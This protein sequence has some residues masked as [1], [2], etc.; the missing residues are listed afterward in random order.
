M[1]T[2]LKVH[3]PFGL[4]TY[5]EDISTSLTSSGFARLDGTRFHIEPAAR[6]DLDALIESFTDLPVDADDSSGLRSRRYGRFIY[7]P[8]TDSLVDIPSVSGPDSRPVVE[9]FQ[10][11]SLNST[12]GGKCR[13]FAALEPAIRSN[14]VLNELIRFDYRSLPVP[15]NWSRLPILVGVHQITLSPGAAR[16]S[17]ATPNHLHRDGE[18]F[19]YVHLMRRKNVK[20]GSNYVAPPDCAGRHPDDIDDEKILSK[21]TLETVL[22]SFVVDDSMVSHHV[23]EVYSIIRNQAS[24]RSVLLVDFTPMMPQFV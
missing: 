17:V 12:D 21:F 20:G 15:E 22:D 4:I 1:K 7:I 24:E 5:P 9:Y 16:P 18:P 3:N 14:P 8:W 13:P 10:P 2:N 6:P 19:T 11:I 23:D